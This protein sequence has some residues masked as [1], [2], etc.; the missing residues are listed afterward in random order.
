ME[1]LV[2]GVAEI[3]SV[4]ECYESED[5]D[6]YVLIFHSR[7]KRKN[8]RE[9]RTIC[10]YCN[11]FFYFALHFFSIKSSAIVLIPLF[12]DTD[13]SALQKRGKLSRHIVLDDDDFIFLGEVFDGLCFE[14]QDVGVMQVVNTS[15]QSTRYRGQSVGFIIVSPILYFV[16]CILSFDE[17]EYFHFGTSE[18]DESDFCIRISVER[19]FWCRCF[20][21]FY[22][23]DSFFVCFLDA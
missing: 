21:G 5:E 13:S 3:G 1:E 10:I 12:I 4:S 7:E 18:S 20:E 19:W 6:Y 14:R 15:R 8:K 17:I 16:L 11:Q 23:S 2:G 22:L 9:E